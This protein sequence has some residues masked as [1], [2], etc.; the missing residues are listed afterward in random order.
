M[1]A[2]IRAKRGDDALALARRALVMTD[3]DPRMGK[4]LGRLLLALGDAASAREI[5]G[6]DPGI[7]VSKA[8]RSMEISLLLWDLDV[9]WLLG[10]GQDALKGYQELAQ[11]S[12]AR[13]LLGTELAWRLALASRPARLSLRRL[14][15]APVLDDEFETIAG[16]LASQSALLPLIERLVMAQ[17][18]LGKLA[19][20]NQALAVLLPWLE[21]GQ[22]AWQQEVLTWKHPVLD[23]AQACSLYV[24]L[25]LK[26]ATVATMREQIAD[27]ERILKRLE[28][29]STD[30]TGTEGLCFTPGI[31]EAIA[32]LRS[33]VLWKR[34]YLG[35]NQEKTGQEE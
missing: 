3:G 15:V 10:R 5:L 16:E 21:Q 14:L 31:L 18:L 28:Q 19:W 23:R 24:D 30:L 2:A 34:Q 17:K 6:V 8:N 32:D 22:E 9:R 35:E 1:G 4:E 13:R 12:A 29:E 26:T 20:E 25:G 27:A 7:D 11:D 33:R